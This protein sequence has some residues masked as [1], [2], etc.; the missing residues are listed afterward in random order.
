MNVLPNYF[1]ETIVLLDWGNLK[2]KAYNYPKP[3]RKTISS[4]KFRVVE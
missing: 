1:E 4:A 3:D 2:D